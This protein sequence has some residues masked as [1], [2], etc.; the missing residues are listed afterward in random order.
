MLSVR[1]WKLWK[2]AWVWF[3]CLVNTQAQV[4]NPFLT[5]IW[6]FQENILS[7]HSTACVRFIPCFYLSPFQFQFCLSKSVIYNRG[8]PKTRVKSYKKLCSST[9]QCSCPHFQFRW[10]TQPLQVF[11][12]ETNPVLLTAQHTQKPLPK[13]QLTS[14]GS[15][16]CSLRS[17]GLEMSSLNAFLSA[18]PQCSA[19]TWNRYSSW[20]AAPGTFCY[21][22]P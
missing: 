10:E 18:R 21:R 9:V 1:T 6:D 11:I 4:R 13:A 14:L 22:L 12:C 17:R 5:Y 2:S 3:T 20:A 16:C 15:G 19:D 8:Y 7:F